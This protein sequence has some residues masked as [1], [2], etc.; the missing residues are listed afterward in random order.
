MVRITEDS[1]EPGSQVP[2]AEEPER[3]AGQAQGHSTGL[4]EKA[5][6]RLLAH[7]TSLPTAWHLA[8]ISL[9]ILE[10]SGVVLKTL[11]PGCLDSLRAQA[12][13]VATE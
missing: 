5:Q 6:P 8:K 9:E 11:G 10:A 2:N 12:S 3:S 1:G 4:L 7:I 13:Q